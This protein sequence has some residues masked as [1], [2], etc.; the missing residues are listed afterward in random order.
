MT[1]LTNYAENLL[2]KW[3]MTTDS[4]TRPTAWYV[5][6]GTGG[7]DTGISGE[8]SGNGY[9]RQAVTTTV[10]GSD[11]SNSGAVTFGPVSGSAWGNM[12][13]IGI[14]DASTSGNCLWS[15][16]LPAAKQMDPGDSLTIPIG[17]LD[18]AFA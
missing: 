10:S 18:L 2:M 15:K 5:A 7:D 9:A 17:D 3:L 6:L 13:R 1:D 11:G 12:T 16:D 4:A 8:P 14:F